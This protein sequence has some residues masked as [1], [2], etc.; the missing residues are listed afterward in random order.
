MKRFEKLAYLNTLANESLTD[1]DYNSEVKFHNEFMKVAQNNRTYKVLEFNEDLLDIADKTGVSVMKIKFLNPNI[2]GNTVS[3]GTV[4]KLGPEPK[5]DK[6]GE[7]TISAG[8]TA[9]K[10]AKDFK[11]SV[12]NLQKMNPGLDI[13]RLYPGDR[14]KVPVMKSSLDEMPDMMAE[15]EPMM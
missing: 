2:K 12:Q 14:I 11:T 1:N 4:I 8:E 10:I 3:Q 6:P 15:D 9:T 5:K 13:N 7:H